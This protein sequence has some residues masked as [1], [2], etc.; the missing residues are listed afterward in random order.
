MPTAPRYTPQAQPSVLPTIRA[1]RPPAGGVAALAPGLGRA[2]SAARRVAADAKRK[3]DETTVWQA[4]ADLGE[5]ETERFSSFFQLRGTQVPDA[6]DTLI[7]DYDGKVSE[8]L[9]DMSADQR[10]RFLPSVQRSMETVR[11]RVAIH[12]SKQLDWARDKALTAKRDSSLSRALTQIEGLGQ[13]GDMEGIMD[14]IGDAD[15]AL[16]ELLRGSEPETV[17]RAIA[18]QRSALHLQALEGFWDRGENELAESWY[19]IFK[20]AILPEHRGDIEDDLAADSRARKGRG[21]ADAAIEGADSYGAA[22]ESLQ[23]T[24]EGKDE[25]TRTAAQARFDYRQTRED[26]ARTKGEDARYRQLRQQ[27]EEK[28]Y[29]EFS[30]AQRRGISPG[31]DD[32]LRRFSAQVHG[33]PAKIDKI[34]SARALAVAT[35]MTPDQ[36][37][38]MSDEKYDAL[39]IGRVTTGEYTTALNR[40]QKILNA[41][42]STDAAILARRQRVNAGYFEAGFSSSL[43]PDSGS[44][45]SL[46]HSRFL[47]AYDERVAGEQ[48]VN[49]G[50]LP[51][52]RDIEIMKE[53]L[54]DTVTVTKG[55]DRLLPVDAL[56]AEQLE[57]AHIEWEEIPDYV[58]AAFTN[59]FTD[60]GGL[61]PRDKLEKLASKWRAGDPG[62]QAIVRTYQLSERGRNDRAN[63][64]EATLRAFRLNER[65]PSEELL[66]LATDA[67]LAKDD[68][69]VLGMIRNAPR[70]IITT[71]PERGSDEWWMRESEALAM[72]AL[73]RGEQPRTLLEVEEDQP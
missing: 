24:L 16:T 25:D 6:A 2:A 12:E 64:K 38:Q 33:T 8:L 71:E 52:G 9:A 18:E 59:W 4:E 36:H 62:L 1:P 66:E 54:G 17:D 41:E 20:A 51:P 45:E 72:Q 65:E 47:L 30:R 61:P 26:A 67:K 37:R 5:F 48:A 14:A 56:S 63:A 10:Q 21:L 49:D 34:D 23:K 31:Q 35:R 43:E 19:G 32:A 55:K 53:M 42:P 28:P 7:S 70:A 69:A 60:H 57:G 29:E 13:T 15:A 46:E 68:A 11:S 27:V 58:Q 44:D 22:F 40:R 3:A 50:K 73:E 39:L